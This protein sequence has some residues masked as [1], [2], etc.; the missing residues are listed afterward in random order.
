[1]SRH[2]A[3]TLAEIRAALKAERDYLDAIGFRGGVVPV[4]EI[5]ERAGFFPSNEERSSVEVADFCADKPER[6]F[7]YHGGDKPTPSNGGMSRT[8]TTWTGDELGRVIEY[9][10]PFVSSLGDRRQNFRAMA[11]NGE[12]YAGTAYLSAGDYVRMRRVKPTHA[13]EVERVRRYADT[14]TR[15]C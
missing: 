3:H 5:K 1:M 9:R 7:A 4:D 14:T 13:G 8:L 15:P 12:I 11:I 2:R 6:Y 10:T